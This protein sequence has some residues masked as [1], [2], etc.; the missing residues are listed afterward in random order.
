MSHPH[1]FVLLD[2][3]LVYGEPEAGV[4]DAGAQH[5]HGSTEGTHTLTCG[6]PHARIVVRKAELD[7]RRQPELTRDF[8]SNIVVEE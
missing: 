3:H 2:E 6:I 8:V 7:V 5:G 1:V 4:D